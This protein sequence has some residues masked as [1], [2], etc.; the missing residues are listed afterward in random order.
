MKPP[1]RPAIRGCSPPRSSAF[2]AALT[3]ADPVGALEAGR[4][5]L[6]VAED[7]GNRGNGTYLAKLL[8]PNRGRNGDSLGA[9]HYIAVA[10]HNYH[11]SGNPTTCEH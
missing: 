1:R 7:S 3:H 8:C 9:L 11:D 2:G 4:R 5:G 6:Q 10:I